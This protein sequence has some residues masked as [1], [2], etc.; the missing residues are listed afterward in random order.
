MFGECMII[1][2][3]PESPPTCAVMPMFVAFGGPLIEWRLMPRVVRYTAPLELKGTTRP[4]AAAER[5]C[6]PQN[7]QVCTPAARLMALKRS[8]AGKTLIV[9]LAERDAMRPL[10][11]LT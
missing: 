11:P 1:F 7:D 8:F 3:R 9:N 10:S 6:A 5:D 4:T 2:Q